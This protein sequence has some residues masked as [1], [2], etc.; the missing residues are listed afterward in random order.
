MRLLI[1][2]T[3]ILSSLSMAAF[4]LDMQPATQTTQTNTQQTTTTQVPAVQTTINTLQNA[5]NQ[6]NQAVQGT[7]PAA[8]PG[9]QPAISATPSVTNTTTTTTSTTVPSMTNFGPDKDKISYSLGVQLG[10]GLKMRQ[11][12]I[13]LDRMI[14]GIRDGYSGSQLQ[15]NEKEIKDTIAN[16][17]KTMMAK[18][19]QKYNTDK[20]ANKLAEKQF[21]EKNRKQP[22]VVTLADGLQ[23]KIINT[24]K[25]KQPTD[26]DT[27]V[28]NYQG[29]TLDG[30]EF[31]SS[32]K[33]GQPMTA[34][35]QYMIPGWVE[36]LKMMKTGSTWMLYVPAHLAYGERGVPPV[37]GPNQTLIF[38]VELVDVKKS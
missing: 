13:D 35:L 18:M 12:D 2:G 20:D 28:V 31:D 17:Q 26:K 34:Q 6:A 11:V 29:T 27:I 7:Q 36:A 4:A 23:Y 15:M 33:R 32:Y 38:K 8:Q 5:A 14:Q 1:T 10:Q 37:I 24:G 3:L 9:T 22:G 16:Y 25:G 21:F 19:M 30:K